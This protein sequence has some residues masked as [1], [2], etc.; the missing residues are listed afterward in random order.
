MIKKLIEKLVQYSTLLNKQT[1]AKQQYPK[2][3]S[4]RCTSFLNS[5]P[6]L[7]KKSSGRRMDST[8]S[9]EHDDYEV[10]SRAHKICSDHL[11][12]AWSKISPCEMSFIPI[13]LVINLI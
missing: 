3:A 12:G 7:N 5:Y 13:R 9:T 6:E 4:L 8:L 10:R 2:I 11:G 1:Q